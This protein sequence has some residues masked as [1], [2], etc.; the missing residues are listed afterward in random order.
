MERPTLQKLL[1]DIGPGRIDVVVV[2]DQAPTAIIGCPHMTK[3]L[4]ML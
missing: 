3:P 1:A 4:K 2:S